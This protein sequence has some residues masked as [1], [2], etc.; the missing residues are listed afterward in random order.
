VPLQERRRTYLRGRPGGLRA[1]CGTA[2]EDVL[3]FAC[4][5]L[6]R[7]RR[8]AALVAGI[9]VLA[10]PRK[11]AGRAQAPGISPGWAPD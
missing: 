6:D 2:G 4:T 1:F 5:L 10:L 3:V 9:L 7:G 11:P 8:L